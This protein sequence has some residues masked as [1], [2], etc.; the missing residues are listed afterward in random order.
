[1]AYKGYF[2]T[3]KVSN[4]LNV[5]TLGKIWI[6]TSEDEE[7][8]GYGMVH[9]RP[10][11]DAAKQKM[12]ETGKPKRRKSGTIISPKGEKVKFDCLSHFCKE[13]GL[14]TGHVSELLNGK[15]KTVKG[16][17]YGI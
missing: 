15:R 9:N 8:G 13:N 12:R 6:D 10:H 11:T 14:S 3:D 16:W 2:D 4:L 17:T 5:P 7:V 1:M